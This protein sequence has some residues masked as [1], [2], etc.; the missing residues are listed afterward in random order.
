MTIVE[1]IDQ[2]GGVSSACALF[3]VTRRTLYQWRIQGCIPGS[4]L[5]D[6]AEKLSIPLDTLRPLARP[7]YTYKNARNGS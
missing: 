6:I 1:L 5:I 3:G 4:R 7:P 2:A